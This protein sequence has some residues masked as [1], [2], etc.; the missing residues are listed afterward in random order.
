MTMTT[1][2]GMITATTTTTTTTHTLTRPAPPA[3]R[4]ARLSHMAASLTA[5]T[6]IAKAPSLR[7]ALDLR[8]PLSPLPRRPLSTRPHG[9][10]R[11]RRL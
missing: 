10:H 11:P 8:S 4:P 5:T 9:R 6:G 2:T 3:L 7:P 1:I